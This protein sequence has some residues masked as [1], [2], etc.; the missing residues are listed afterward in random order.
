MASLDW[1]YGFRI[2]HFCAQLPFFLK[3]KNRLDA[4]HIG[5]EGEAVGKVDKGCILPP[6]PIPGAGFLGMGKKLAEIWT[7]DHVFRT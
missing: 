4:K 3:P 2:F 5:L 6:T 7:D 1:K